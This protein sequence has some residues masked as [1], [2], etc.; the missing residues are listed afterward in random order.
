MGVP[1]MQVE[2]T[3]YLQPSF[4]QFS[5]KRDCDWISIV[6]VF[7]LPGAALDSSFS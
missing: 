2:P 6:T 5:T 1:F 3:L 7:G 4:S